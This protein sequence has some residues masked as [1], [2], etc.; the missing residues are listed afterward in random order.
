[1]VDVGATYSVL[2]TLKGKLSQGTVNVI[3]AT[4]VSKTGPFF[5]PLKFK[6]GKH[7]V[8]HQLLYKPN[9]PQ[10]LLGRDFLE[11]LEAEIKFS[12]GGGVEVVIPETK[13]VEAAAIFIQNYGEIPKEVEAVIPIVW[14]NDFPGPCLWSY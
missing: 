5:Q 7:W 4:G 1:M 10:P 2:D 9:S 3:G 12:K 13:F 14:A 11:K 8:V 6:L